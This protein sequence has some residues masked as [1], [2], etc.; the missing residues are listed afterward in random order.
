MLSSHWPELCHLD[1]SGFEEDWG[2]WFNSV[3][4]CHPIQ[5]KDTVAK[6]GEWISTSAHF[7]VLR[8]LPTMRRPEASPSLLVQCNI[9]VY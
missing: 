4:H 3:A 8:H 9:N 1:I 7:P 6:K 2:M 5:N